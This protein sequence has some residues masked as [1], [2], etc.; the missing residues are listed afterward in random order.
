MSDLGQ[1][2]CAEDSQ[3]WPCGIGCLLAANTALSREIVS[4][5]ECGNCG[6]EWDHAPV[7]VETLFCRSGGGQACAEYA[8]TWESRAK[9]AEARLRSQAEVEKVMSQRNT[10]LSERLAAVTTA[11]ERLTFALDHQRWEK[12]LTAKTKALEVL[13]AGQPAPAA[14]PSMKRPLP[15]LEPLPCHLGGPHECDESGMIDQPAAAEEA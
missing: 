9:L 12:V 11:L 4:H 7:P 5:W 2:F 14:G 1:M 6:R 15:H 8:V 10:A 3:H 13:A